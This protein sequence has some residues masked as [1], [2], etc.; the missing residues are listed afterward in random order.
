MILEQNKLVEKLGEVLGYILSYL[1]FTTII[2]FILTLLKKIP[3]AWAYF[4]IMSITILIA[5][6]GIILKKFLK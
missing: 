6:I 4:N 5:L 1:I 2:F 3:E